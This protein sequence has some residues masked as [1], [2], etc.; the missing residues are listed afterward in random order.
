MQETATYVFSTPIGPVSVTGNEEGLTALSRIDEPVPSPDSSLPVWAGEVKRQLAEYFE[1]TRESFDL[2]LA[3]QGTPFQMRVWLGL[4]DI[5]F[6][7][8]CSYMDLSRKLGDQK[9]IR[10]VGR[11]NGQN[12]IAIIIPCHRVIGSDGSLTGYAGGL[13]M[14]K[15]LLDHEARLAGTYQMNLNF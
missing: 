3:P 11:A 13:E 9:A 12:P 8:T 14:K 15:N 10:A 6:G 5:P 7:K 2:P 4:L 1:G